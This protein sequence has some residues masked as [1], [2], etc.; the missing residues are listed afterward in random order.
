MEFVNEVAKFIQMNGM[1]R[2]L[3]LPYI[4][5]G[6]S[7]VE[8]HIGICKQ[9]TIK[10]LTADAVESESWDLYLNPLSM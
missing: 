9:S 3:S 2:S 4:T 6:N 7:V 5:S 10:A 8:S 1:D